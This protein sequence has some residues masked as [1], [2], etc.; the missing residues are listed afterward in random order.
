MSRSPAATVLAIC[1]AIS[2]CQTRTVEMKPEGD[3]VPA[4]PLCHGWK[5]SNPSA[6]AAVLSA[7]R[8]DKGHV[9]IRGT[10]AG[11]RPPSELIVRTQIGGG[12]PSPEQTEESSIVHRDAAG[13]WRISRVEF[14]PHDIPQ[15]Q[16]EF[17][18]EGETPRPI[19]N[20]PNRKVYEG[21]LPDATAKL[22][23]AALAGP[24]F[25]DEP[26]R[27]RP[28][29]TGNAPEAPCPLDSSGYSLEIIEKGRSRVHFRSCHATWTG[30]SLLD[31][32]AGSY[33]ELRDPPAQP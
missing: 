4:Q 27:A 15:P 10:A 6:D 5:R 31:L 22:I 16:Y 18:V 14:Y 17:V 13:A 21:P 11:V 25:R 1:L 23:E 12:L 7:E 2:G 9:S 20:K 24:C 28:R 29:P 32:V 8:M 30:G 19:P 26:V 3:S 33:P